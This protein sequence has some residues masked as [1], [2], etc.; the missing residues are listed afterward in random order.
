MSPL[1]NDVKEKLSIVI[2][3]AG[4]GTRLKR[5]VK[6]IP[7]PLIKIERLNNISILHHTINNLLTFKVKN[8]A[9]VI[10]HLGNIIREFITVLKNKIPTLY[11]KLII[12]DSGTQYKM[13]PLYSLLSITKNTDF[14]TMK[15]HFL[16]F[17]GDTIFDYN[18]LKEVFSVISDN[19]LLINKY[20][21]VFYQNMGLKSLKEIYTEKSSIS[22]A[23]IELI[24]SKITLKR[25]TKK[26][27]EDLESREV[28]NHVIPIIALNYDTINYFLNL[29]HKF[30]FKTL[31]ETLN[32]IVMKGKKI[33][34]FKIKNEHKFYDIDNKYDLKKQKKEKDN[35]CSD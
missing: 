21:F 25:F 22:N 23:E 35:R 32:H 34:C 18:L 24:D 30:H 33:L 7:K 13:G 9:I 17:P 1:K 20:P 3:C 8:I 16:I 29:E 26:K 4:E 28:V 19:F 11:N 6:K 10:G 12:I 31:W 14:Y 27:V 15:S 5:I 2:L